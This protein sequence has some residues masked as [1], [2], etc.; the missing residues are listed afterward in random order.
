MADAAQRA[1]VAVVQKGTMKLAAI[2]EANGS[3]YHVRGYNGQRVA[4]SAKQDVRAFNGRSGTVHRGAVRGIPEGFWEIVEHGSR[5]HL[6]TSRKGRGGVG[7][8]TRSGR[9]AARFFTSRQVLRRFAEGDTLG[10]LQPL[11]TPYGPRQ[12][13][14]HP[15]HG[16]IGRPWAQSMLEGGKVIGETMETENFYQMANV[17]ARGAYS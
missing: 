3:R 8:V 17:W 2:V 16:S 11:R 12:F 1:N 9:T 4:L 15:G 7:R 6:I 13:V 5:P 14:Q 10:Q